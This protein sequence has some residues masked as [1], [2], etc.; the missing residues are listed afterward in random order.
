MK[1]RFPV[2]RRLR[3]LANSVPAQEVSSAR[4][5]GVVR[6]PRAIPQC[7]MGQIDQVVVLMSTVYLRPHHSLD[8][9]APIW[10]RLSGHRCSPT[11]FP[12]LKY[13]RSRDH[14]TTTLSRPRSTRAKLA[15]PLSIRAKLAH[16]MAK[17]PEDSFNYAPTNCRIVQVAGIPILVCL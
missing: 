7:R 11:L 3:H 2:A 12:W 9:Q 17:T 5:T 13:Q 6:P 4:A 15:H 14:T 10:P 1:G 16:R 8:R